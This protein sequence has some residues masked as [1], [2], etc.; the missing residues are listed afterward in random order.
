MCKGCASGLFHTSSDGLH[1]SVAI[2]VGK[3]SSKGIQQRQT[4]TPHRKTQRGYAI[5]WAY[6]NRD[7]FSPKCGGPRPPLDPNTTALFRAATEAA[8]QVGALETWS[9]RYLVGTKVAPHAKGQEKTPARRPLH[10]PLK[11]DAEGETTRDEWA[12]QYIVWHA[13]PRQKDAAEITVTHHITHT[14][15]VYEL[16]A[17]NVLITHR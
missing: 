15:R 6:Q 17:P 10:P 7:S 1:T 16:T 8:N 4:Q 3:T 9:P 2:Y 12:A 13:I 11:L 5:R 14:T